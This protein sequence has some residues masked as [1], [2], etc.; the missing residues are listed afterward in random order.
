MVDE[1]HGSIVM[2][3]T[4]SRKMGT[5]DQGEELDAIE[6]QTDEEE[7][8]AMEVEYLFRGSAIFQM[9]VLMDPL[10]ARIASRSFP[11]F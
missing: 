6:R 3:T 4:S 10:C 11:T 1:R 8:E 2:E 7:A 5:N 9:V